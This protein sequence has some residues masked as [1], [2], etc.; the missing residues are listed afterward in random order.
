M[1]FCE[2]EL[3]S[4]LKQSREKNLRLGFTG[5][6]LYKRGEFMQALEGEER[7]VE[8]MYSQ[9]EKDS[10]H[11][12]CSILRWEVLT[13]R[14]FPDW[15]MGFKDLQDVDAQETPGYRPFLNEPLTSPKFQADPSRV[16]KLLLAFRDKP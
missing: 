11:R 13:E 2:N 7:S 8:K 9:I 4:L 15:S 12:D 3:V 1:S 6:L 16:Q 14:R 10:R 5:L